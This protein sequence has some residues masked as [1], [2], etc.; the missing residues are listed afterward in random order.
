MQ[1]YNSFTHL[2]DPK[3][4]KLL[5]WLYFP[6]THWVWFSNTKE[7]KKVN[8]ISKQEW[9][10]KRKSQVFLV[11]LEQITTS[12]VENQMNGWLVLNSQVASKMWSSK[13]QNLTKYCERITLRKPHEN[14]D[15]RKEK[16]SYISNLTHTLKN[17]IP[18][19]NSGQILS[20]IKFLFLF[21]QTSLSFH[22]I[23][24]SKVKRDSLGGQ[25]HGRVVEFAHSAA[26]AQGLDPG[27]GHGT[28][29]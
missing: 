24:F 19:S 27:H 20:I 11:L 4:F 22:I 6:R 3:Y 14:W 16:L 21:F 5:T 13:C 12:P 2:F 9:I 10:K 18:E 25:L 1:I 7:K 28:A 23:E 17:K 26:A 15:Q 29:H 8:S